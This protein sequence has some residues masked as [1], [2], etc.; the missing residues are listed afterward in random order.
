[1]NWWQELVGNVAKDDAA[2]RA[3]FDHLRNLGI[4][5]AVAYAGV[6]SLFKHDHSGLQ[7][8]IDA[9]AAAMAF[10]LATWLFWVNQAQ[11]YRLLR[12]RGV[13]RTRILI[14]SQCYNWLAVAIVYSLAA[15]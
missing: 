13:S 3:I 12:A 11:G 15:K 9:A 10:T 4:C 6:W 5:G 8:L 7:Y 1:M 14:F 2:V